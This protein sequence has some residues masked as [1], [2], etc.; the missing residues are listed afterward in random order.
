MKNF[1]S[2]K[3]KTIDSKLL[4]SLIFGVLCNIAAVTI[5]TIIFSFVLT[6]TNKYPTDVINYISAAFLGIGGLIGG[7]IAGRINQKAGLAVGALSGFIVFVI[8]L[9]IGLSQSVGTITIITL[10][11]LIVLVIFGSL[12]G[13]LGVNKKKNIK[14]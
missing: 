13:V 10:I 5:L 4:R 12:G 1:I 9:I 6:L 11:K 14:I 2:A 3:G 8:I 7:Y